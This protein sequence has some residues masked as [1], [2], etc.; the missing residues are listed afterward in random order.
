VQRVDLGRPV[1]DA[2]AEA[3]VGRR[4]ASSAPTGPQPTTTTSYDC[5]WDPPPLPSVHAEPATPPHP[6][7]LPQRARG[8]AGG[9]CAGLPQRRPALRR[10]RDRGGRGRASRRAR[11]E[12]LPSASTTSARTPPTPARPTPPSRP[13]SSCSTGC[14][15]PG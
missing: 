5:T 1:H 4:S 8:E 9:G 10:G 2:R 13:T 7:R 14:R 11:R 15:R 12:G 3:E 6:R